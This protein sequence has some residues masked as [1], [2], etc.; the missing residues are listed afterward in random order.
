MISSLTA[1]T[2]TSYPRRLQVEVTDSQGTLIRTVNRTQFTPYR[3]V[4]FPAI[5]IIG[6]C[7]LQCFT[8][9]TC[10]VVCL[11]RDLRAFSFFFSKNVCSDYAPIVRAVKFVL[12]EIGLRGDHHPTPRLRSAVLDRVIDIER[13]GG[14]RQKLD[15]IILSFVRNRLRML[16][17]V[18]L[19]R[20]A[21][22]TTDIMLQVVSTRY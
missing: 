14:L 5:S 13:T 4:L 10:V 8:Y 22:T 9:T 7:S 16:D 1:T 3:G 19:N 21:I 11:Q 6:A 12:N 15:R 2:D 17:L 18:S 20:T